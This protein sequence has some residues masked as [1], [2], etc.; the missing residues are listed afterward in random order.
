M[1][2]FD[3]NV[4]KILEDWEVHHAIREVIA[5]ALDEQVLTGTQDIQ[6]LEDRQGRWHIRDYGRGLRHE[7]LTLKENDEKLANPCVIGKF[8]IGLKDA[9]ATFERKGVEVSIESRHDCITLGR[10]QKH[11]FEDIVTLHAYVYPP[12][13]QDFVGTEYILSSIRRDDIRK[14]KDLFLRFSGER[15]IETT[16]YGQV[17]GKREE[18]GRIYINGVE[19]AEEENFLF[20]YNITSL[21]KSIRSA[22]NRER[23][24]VG[25]SAYADRVKSILLACRT[26]EVAEHLVDDLTDYA[27]GRTHDE[28][29]WID[30]Q[31]HALKTLNA[32]EKV[33]FLTAED[34]I[35][36]VDMVDEARRAGH[37]VVTIPENLKYRIQG[38]TDISGNPIRDI[39]RFHKEYQES[40]E[41]SFVEPFQLTRPE[42]RVFGVTRTAFALIGGRPDKVKQVAISETMRKEIGSFAQAAGLWEPWTG[43]IIIKR[44]Q[45]R[46]IET[47]V[48]TLLHETAHAVSNASDMSR[49]FET[50]LS[51]LLGRLAA[52]LLG[53]A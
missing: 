43:R 31:E 11:G 17:L 9:L 23:S 14:A 36:A 28:L 35:T 29:K 53:D 34:L 2:K 5:N 24:N 8:G 20:S 25:R 12:R 40:F 38:S 51:T 33:I 42:K 41:F 37:K 3:L 13:D 1:Q 52:K 49:A 18:G 50:Q 45:L 47:Y 10:S 27:T 48:G 15:V 39:G 19:V 7:H 6:I 26:G 32:T 4:E 46:S 44:D 22:L 30:I 21:T 16:R